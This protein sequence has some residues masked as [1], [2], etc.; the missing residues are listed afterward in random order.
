MP[1]DLAEPLFK[2]FGRHSGAR[3]PRARDSDSDPSTIEAPEPQPQDHARRNHLDFPVDSPPNL[4]NMYVYTDKTSL[5]ADREVWGVGVGWVGVSL[6]LTW[7][8]WGL[9][10]NHFISPDLP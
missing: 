5:E 1:W 9:T 4:R 3:T 7:P 8:Q 10:K 2:P 6:G